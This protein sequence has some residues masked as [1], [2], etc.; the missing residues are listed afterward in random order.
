MTVNI[1][2][3]KELDAKTDAIAGLFGAVHAALDFQE[4]ATAY[5]RDRK[6]MTEAKS[7]K[8]DVEKKEVWAGMRKA[9]A[10]AIKVLGLK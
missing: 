4:R 1:L 3:D 8:F 9:H 5:G 7:K 10:K 6:K 2:K